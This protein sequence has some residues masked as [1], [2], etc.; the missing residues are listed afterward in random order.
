MAHSKR[1]LSPFMLGPYYRPQLT[2]VLSLSHR[3]TGVFLVLGAVLLVYWLV[4]VAAGP[5]AYLRAQAVIGSK[6]GLLSL[7]L[8]TWALFF[9][10]GN[11]IRQLFWNAGYGFSMAA[12]YRSGWAVVIASLVLTLLCWIIIT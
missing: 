3:V 2:S 4:A 5:E 1:P 12:V 11:G 8:W 7:F 10:L 6:L 9:H